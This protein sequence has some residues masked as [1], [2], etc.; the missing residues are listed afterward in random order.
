ML[1]IEVRLLAGR[2]GATAY[3]DRTVAEW[4]PHPGRL[5]SAL[6]DTWADADE[7]NPQEHTDLLWLEQQ[8]PP[9]IRCVGDEAVR[10]RR[11]VTVYVPGNDP[12]ALAKVA[13]RERK[14]LAREA[15]VQRWREEPNKRT[16]RAMTKAVDAYHAAVT[17]ASAADPAAPTSVLEVLPEYRNRQPRQYPVVIPDDPL[18][19]FVWPGAEPDPSRRARLDGLLGRVAR[20]GHS[21]TPVACRVAADDAPAALYAP[22]AGGGLFLR[23]PS[24]GLL[25]RLESEFARHQGRRERRLPA[26]LVEY[27]VPRPPRPVTLSGVMAGEWIVI[28]VESPPLQLSRSLEITRALRD[29]LAAASPEAEEYLTGRFADSA[30]RP[31]VAVV[32]LGD[33]GHRWA[34]GLVRGLALV[35]PKDIGAADREMIDRAVSEWQLAG[36]P[37]L[38]ADG[39]AVSTGPPQRAAPVGGGP[40]ALWSDLPYALRRSVWCRPSRR[41]LSATPVALDRHVP[42]LHRAP[43]ADQVAAELLVQACRFAGLPEPAEVTVIPSSA[44]VGVPRAGGRDH[45]RAFPPFVAARSGRLRQSTHATLTFERDVAGPVLLG[46]GRYLG[47]G[48]FLPVDGTGTA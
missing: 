17:A 8:P 47:R 12:T 35:L 21:G 6:V 18:I 22:M 34:T 5:F 1:A 24:P 48:L 42:A 31:H 27:G 13:E 26:R 39:I 20:L 40:A 44:L 16:E 11:P 45:R 33:V 9:H 14:S 30:G 37:V 36:A 46:A 15:A 7:P 29:A 10:R 25:D 2:Y 3:N 41:W 38:L 32:P 4:P 23:V 43:E 19:T 28:P